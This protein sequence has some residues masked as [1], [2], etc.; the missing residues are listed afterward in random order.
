MQKNHAA[1]QTMVI[2]ALLAAIGIAIPMFS[3]VKLIIGPASYTLAS[4]VPIFIAM[5]LS[6][7]VA[8]AVSLVT[9]VGFLLGG[10]PIVIVLRALT[11]VLFAVLGAAFLQKRPNTLN[12][13]SQWIVFA[14]CVSVIHAL[15]EVLVVIP[16]YYGGGLSSASYS[17]GFFVTVV[18]LVGLGGWVHSMVD[19]V[20]ALWVWKALRTTHRIPLG[21][22]AA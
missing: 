4:H 16:F 15:M 20:L 13:P 21:G 1:V 18:A 11:H 5:F 19:F 2:S 14:S 7:A 6:P 12:N 8:V 3:P 17:S 9:T 10:F 22:G